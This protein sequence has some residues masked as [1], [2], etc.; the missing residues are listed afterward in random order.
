MEINKINDFNLETGYNYVVTIALLLHG[1]II[2]TD[3]INVDNLTFNNVTGDE[4]EE[5]LFST[6]EKK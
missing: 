4:F 3:S 2:S 1:C 5:T 6:N